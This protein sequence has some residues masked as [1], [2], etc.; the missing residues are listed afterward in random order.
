M[1]LGLLC[2][3]GQG[4]RQLYHSAPDSCEVLDAVPLSA[5][6]NIN[7]VRIR[8]SIVPVLFLVHVGV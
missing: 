7:S 5:R 6:P 1:I 4:V 3:H 2:I 8:V